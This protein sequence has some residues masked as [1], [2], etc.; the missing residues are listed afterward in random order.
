MQPR[1]IDQLQRKGFWARGQAFL[2]QGIPAKGTYLQQRSLL[3][4]RIGVCLA[5][6][7]NVLILIGYI[8]GSTGIQSLVN[9]C[10]STTLYSLSL[11][12]MLK[13]RNQLGRNLFAVSI[14]FMTWQVCLSIAP[15]TQTA[16]FFVPISIGGTLLWSGQRIKQIAFALISVCGYVISAYTISLIHFHGKVG[17]SNPFHASL[18]LNMMVVFGAT[19]LIAAANEAS[20]ASL[21]ELLIGELQRNQKLLADAM[22]S[23]VLRQLAEEDQDKTT[24]SPNAAAVIVDIA[25]LE[26]LGEMLSEGEV[27][28]LSSEIESRLSF[29]AQRYRLHQI[30]TEGY[31]TVA[32]AKQIDHSQEYLNAALD[33]AVASKNSLGEIMNKKSGKLLFRIGASCTLI[34]GELCP[35]LP[36]IQRAWSQSLDRASR[37]A[38]SAPMQ[39]ILIDADMA[40]K[41]ATRFRLQACGANYAV[42]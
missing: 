16:L 32:I 23:L 20:A 9:L 14:V 24:T 3:L 19:F 36:A 39:Q 25:N 26:R 29:F 22:P 28:A 5:L 18:L 6:L 17:P 38:Q 30:R 7:S 40:A 15:E 35:T 10:A 12:L 37:L 21:Q 42:S 11:A 41:V 8:T 1:Q 33:F 27:L 4:M 34:D 2:Q 13:G 31:A